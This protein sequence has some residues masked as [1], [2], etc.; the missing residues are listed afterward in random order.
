MLGQWRPPHHQLSLRHLDVNAEGEVTVGAQF[1]GDPQQVLP[2]LFRHRGEESLQALAAAEP[3][4]RQHNHYI[5]SVAS[6]GDSVIATSPR[7]G[8]I[9][10]WRQGQFVKLEQLNDVAGAAFDNKRQAFITSNG[11]G[12]LVQFD[13]RGLSLTGRVAELRWDNHMELSS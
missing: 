11:R 8:C 7:G 5:A 1:E 12:Q 9:S 10:L 2:L 4:W 13:Q 3:V 6:A